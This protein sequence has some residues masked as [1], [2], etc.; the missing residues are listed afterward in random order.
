MQSINQAYSTPILNY[1]VMAQGGLTL[2]PSS[3]FFASSTF[4]AS[5]AGFVSALAAVYAATSAA[6]STDFFCRPSSRL[7]HMKRCTCATSANTP[8]NHNHSATIPPILTCSNP[9]SMSTQRDIHLAALYSYS[10]SVRDLAS[11]PYAYPVSYR[12][13]LT[14]PELAPRPPKNDVYDLDAKATTDRTARIWM[15]SPSFAMASFTCSFTRTLSSRMYA[16]SNSAS[17]ASRFAIHPSTILSRI[18]AGLLA[19]SSF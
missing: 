4:G 19:K 5:P 7:N 16:C 12:R 17:S 2:A 8:Q 15:F 18:W 13:P 10:L 11:P 14:T 3:S 1:Q 9:P 6:K